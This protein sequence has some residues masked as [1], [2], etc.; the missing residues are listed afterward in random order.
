MGNI[1]V[2]NSMNFLKKTCQTLRKKKKKILKSLQISITVQ[3]VS[4]IYI[5]C[6]LILFLSLI[7]K[8]GYTSLWMIAFNYITKLEKKTPLYNVYSFQKRKGAF[9]CP[10]WI[11]PNI[12]SIDS[13][14]CIAWDLGSSWCAWFF[15][16][17]GGLFE[18]PSCMCVCVCVCVSITLWPC[19]LHY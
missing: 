12:F 5:M 15:T 1:I 6:V 19:H 7:A 4:L 17:N 11:Y 10:Y 13:K 8:F 16:S 18:I 3:I 2:T 14:A 9:Y